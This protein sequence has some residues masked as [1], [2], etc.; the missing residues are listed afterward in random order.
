MAYCHS[1]DSRRPLVKFKQV[2]SLIRASNL[3][4]H[5]KFF[6]HTCLLPPLP[7]ML[8]TS[9]L[10]AHFFHHFSICLVFSVIA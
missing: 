5:L 6:K 9:V 4:N 10:A 8:T 3:L 2:E 7:V 1:I